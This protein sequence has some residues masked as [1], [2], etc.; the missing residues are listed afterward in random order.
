MLSKIVTKAFY[1][2][3]QRLVHV[4]F[5]WVSCI[6]ENVIM[7]TC[8]LRLPY[9]FICFDACNLNICYEVHEHDLIYCIWLCVVGLVD[10]TGD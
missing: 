9:I 5:I 10:I 2:E 4:T 7:Q 1:S 3:D 8:L 6:I